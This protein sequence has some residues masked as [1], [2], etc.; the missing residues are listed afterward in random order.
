[1]INQQK[2]LNEICLDH[3]ESENHSA[4]ADAVALTLVA[5]CIGENSI[6]D[7]IKISRVTSTN[8]RTLIKLI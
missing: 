6:N 5:E 7:E 2:T 3:G 8:V 4:G 1:M